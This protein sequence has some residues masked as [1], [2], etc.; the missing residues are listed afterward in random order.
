MAQATFEAL[1]DWL[2]TEADAG[3]NHELHLLPIPADGVPTASDF[4]GMLMDGIDLA[5]QGEIIDQDG[6]EWLVVW[7]FGM[8]FVHS[9]EYD[10]NESVRTMHEVYE[11]IDA[12]EES[13]E[14]ESQNLRDTYDSLR[15]DLDSGL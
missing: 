6:S 15:K 4:F 5:A 7:A 8:H 1:A 14:E 2:I 3:E 10:V 12:T 13:A 11:F 9:Y